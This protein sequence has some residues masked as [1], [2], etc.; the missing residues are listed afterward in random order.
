MSIFNP[1][2]LCIGMAFALLGVSAATAAQ[3]LPEAVSRNGVLY[4]TGGIGEDEA[5]TFRSL[6]PRYTLRMTFTSAA[7]NYLSDVDVT[8]ADASGRGVLDT[9][10]E[11]PFLFVM[12]PVGR[13]RIVAH[14]G[15]TK[16]TRVVEIRR[17][18]GTEIRIVLQERASAAAQT[19][20]PHCRAP[21][22]RQGE[23]RSW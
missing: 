16:V 6:A 10:T 2:L 1:R 13:Y 3:A 22:R 12:L 17:R 9:L 20:C 14:A 11:G 4:M 7:G 8:I 18:G 19:N 23:A 15:N 21:M 5:K